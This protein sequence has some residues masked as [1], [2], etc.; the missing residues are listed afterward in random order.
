MKMM[1]KKECII[2]KI[3]SMIRSGE[4][5]VGTKLP[6]GTEFAVSLGVSHVTL[7]TALEELA[8]EGIVTLVHGKGTFVTGDGTV[9]A[10]GKILIVKSELQT[11]RGTS[12]Y[13]LSGFEK[14][15]CE[16]QL[17]TETVSM[18]FLKGSSHSS[19][20]SIIRKN[21]FTG[22]LIPGGGFDE[23]DP[24]A[25]LLQVCGAPVLIA[26]GTSLDPERTGF[27]VMRTD[28]A[29]AWNDGA[30]FL[31]S[32]G[33]KRCA[34]LANAVFK[35]KYYSREEFLIRFE[36]LGFDADP[37][38]ITAAAPD[39]QSFESTLEKLLKAKPD[40]IFCGSDF[41]AMRV[42]QYLAARKIRVP[43][44]IAVLGFGGYPGGN[45]CTPALSTMDFQYNLIGEKAAEFMAEPQLL[46]EKHFDIFT[47][48]RILIR[49]STIQ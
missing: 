25:A 38:L 46:H 4:L 39:D 23:N 12:N 16:L 43:E 41:F 48:H 35:V 33:V 30:S 1:L 11:L 17:I 42:C 9:S 29:A 18:D 34:V 44:D 47:P 27:P 15:C 26:H 36:D 24:L 14:R 19:F 7:R 28:Y 20:R 6:R 37:Q 32:C 5:P 40:A 10:A 21:G 3:K 49:E 22:V 31:R 8:K 2:Q 13:L 45:F